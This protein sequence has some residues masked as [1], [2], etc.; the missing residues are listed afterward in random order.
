[1]VNNPNHT[2]LS[3][4]YFE[5]VDQGIWNKSDKE[6]VELGKQELEKIGLITAG[7]VVDGMIMRIS[8]AYPVY[9][10]G[11]EKHL[12]AVLDFLAQ[13]SNLELM[14]RNGQ[15]KYNNMD[16]AMISAWDA[17]E[18]SY[19]QVASED[20]SVSTKKDKTKRASL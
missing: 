12:N 4:E 15:H 20:R 5:N 17:V 10:N 13:F 6:L 9:D 14:G 16:I 19:A 8:D 11:Y 7:Q 18:S 1:M 2:A 3:L